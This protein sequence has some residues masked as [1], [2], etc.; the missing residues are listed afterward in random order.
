M[1][2]NFDSAIE[3]LGENLW[4]PT[5]D[6]AQQRWRIENASTFHYVPTAK[7]LATTRAIDNKIG[8]IWAIFDTLWQFKNSQGT[9]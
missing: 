9:R 7:E 6:Y 1:W 4:N 2:T 5:G 3:K 8:R